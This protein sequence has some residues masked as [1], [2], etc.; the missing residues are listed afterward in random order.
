MLANVLT[1]CSPNFSQFGP[2]AA[3]LELKM[4]V[5]L[6]YFL[7]SRNREKLKFG[8]IRVLSDYHTKG[9]ATEESPFYITMGVWQLTWNRYKFTVTAAELVLWDGQLSFWHRILHDEPSPF[10]DSTSSIIFPSPWQNM[11]CR[12]NWSAFQLLPLLFIHFLCFDSFLQLYFM[13]TCAHFA[14]LTGFVI[15]IEFIQQFFLVVKRPFVAFR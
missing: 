15:A 10:R 5:Q 8:G 12:K 7:L 11:T 14:M 9:E 3:D 6:A 4:H 2:G 1:T 13:P